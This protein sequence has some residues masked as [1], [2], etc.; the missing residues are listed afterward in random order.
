[1]NLVMLPMWMLSGIF[2]S[3]K[4]YP[5]QIQPFIRALPLT[6]LLDALRPV[7]VKG[8]TLMQHGTEIGIL[9]AW[10]TLS[11]ALALRFFRWT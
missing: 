1:M 10:A 9:F 6:A 11:Y 2:F 5:E 4:Y 7:M 8:E 3:S